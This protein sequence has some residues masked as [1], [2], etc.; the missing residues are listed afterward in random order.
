LGRHA[1]HSRTALGIKLKGKNM[2][3]LKVRIMILSEQDNIHASATFNKSTIDEMYANHGISF[4][5]QAYNML[6]TELEQK[7]QEEK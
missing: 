6:L 1:F 5:D 4:V 3:N 7:Q 2:E